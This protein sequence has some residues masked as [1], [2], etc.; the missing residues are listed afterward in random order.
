[1][2]TFSLIVLVLSVA[3]TMPVTASDE[4]G[5]Y[6]SRGDI[7]CGEWLDDRKIGGSPET[8]ATSWILGY[9]SAYNAQ[10]PDV[11]D[12]T[13]G[14]EADSISLSMDKFCQMFPLSH[15]SDGVQVLIE[16]LWPDRQRIADDVSIVRDELLEKD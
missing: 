10:T 2:K 3:I 8:T 6:M 7:S 9:I 11:Y 5:M 12:I 14:I 15:L 13:Y 1:M 4:D 16:S